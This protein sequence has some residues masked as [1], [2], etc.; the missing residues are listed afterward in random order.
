M[1][2]LVDFGYDSTYDSAF[3]LRQARFAEFRGPDRRTLYG[4]SGDNHSRFEFLRFLKVIGPPSD[5]A[6]FVGSVTT[7]EAYD[8][9]RARVDKVDSAK[10]ESLRMVCAG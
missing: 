10:S 4:S 1:R 6:R 8:E 7:Q 5:K 2:F 3:S 9:S